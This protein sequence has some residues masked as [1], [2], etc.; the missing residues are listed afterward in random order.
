M[1][2]RLRARLAEDSERG[3]VTTLE[4]VLLA[5]AVMAIFGLMLFGGRYALA[6]SSIEQA[7]NAAARA[8]SSAETESQARDAASQI[9][10]T[11]LA[12]QGLNCASTDVNVDT[13]AF[14]LPPGHIG[15]VD[16]SV[17]C[18]LNL[19]DLVWI[20]VGPSLTLEHEA[21]SVLDAYRPRGG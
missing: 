5:P 14:A 7:S 20:P 4:V 1:I 6:N 3:A 9:A 2:R 16:V 17:T 8:A 11:T 19:S 12:N 13:S 15:T 21:Q 18:V 10:D